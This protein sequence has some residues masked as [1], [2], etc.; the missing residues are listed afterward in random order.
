MQ[1]RLRSDVICDN[2]L[3]VGVNTEYCHVDWGRSL[4]AGHGERNDIL[5]RGERGEGDNTGEI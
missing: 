3:R 5:T 1:A 2:L 4:S